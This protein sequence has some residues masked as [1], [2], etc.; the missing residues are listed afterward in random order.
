[1]NFFQE[2]GHCDADTNI[3]STAVNCRNILLPFA[4]TTSPSA[5]VYDNRT[6]RVGH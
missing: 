3:I 1:M 5:G 4:A 2:S 6:A